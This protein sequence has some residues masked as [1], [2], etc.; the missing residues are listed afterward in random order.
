MP[1]S[2][3][4]PST[5]FQT[6]QLAEDARFE[7][8][9]SSISVVFDVAPLAVQPMGSFDATVKA[10]HLGSLLVGDLHFAE[11]QFL[12]AQPRVARDGLD[13]YLVQWYRTGGFV[14]QCDG[15]TDVEVSGGDIVIL[16]LGRTLRTFARRSHVMTLIVPRELIH[17]A[18]GVRDSDLHGTVLRA[19]SALGG[20]LSDH[21]LSLQH[22]LPGIA[23]DDS[24]AVARASVQM[25]A[26][27]L[28][29]SARTL[30]EA[31]HSIEGVTLER[32]QR[33]I[34]RHLGSDLSADALSREF[35]ISRSALYRLFEPL[36]GVA[37]HVQLRRLLQAHHAL[38]NPANRKL[39]VADVAS[40]AG[41]SSNAH[42]SRAFRTAFGM[43][44]SDLRAPASRGPSDTASGLEAHWQG[45]SA[46]YAAWVRGLANV[47]DTL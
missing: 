6:D 10:T 36:G 41:F 43:A 27:C 11:Q 34:N 20:L 7:A 15:S 1:A 30:Q 2:N 29:P 22:R 16:D 23:L 47:T 4:L 38:A 25:L 33:H 28:L 40:R 32:I 9:R 24:P 18:M 8:W 31:R 26:A 13:H 3:A 21:L 37:H 17:E 5:L 19:H 45:N 12:R 39:R 14:G 42:F 35:G 46:E 44:P